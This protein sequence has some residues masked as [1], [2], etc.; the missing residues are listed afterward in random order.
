MKKQKHQRKI[1]KIKVQKSKKVSL[2]KKGVLKL[3]KKNNQT[4]SKKSLKKKKVKKRAVSRKI[5]NQ[6]PRIKIKIVGIGGGGNSIVS[7]VAQ[8]IKKV[9]FVVANTDFQ[10]LSSC[11]RGIKRLWFGQELTQ[12][13][14]AGM[15]PEVG[16][17][18]AEKEKEKLAKIFDGVDFSI[19]IGSLGGGTGSGA[20]PL[21]ASLARDAGNLTLGIFTM[22]FKFEGER[23]LKIAQDA[24]E[25]LK[26]NFNALIII[27][28][29]KVFEIIKRETGFKKSLSCVNECLAD[30]LGGLI[31]MIYSPGLI[32]IDFADVKTILQGKGKIAYLNTAT[33]KGPNKIEE[34]VKKVLK[35]PLYEYNISGAE[36]ILFNITSGKDLKMVEA[37]EISRIISGFNPRAKIIFGISQNSKYNNKIKITLFAVGCGNGIQEKIKK[38]IKKTSIKIKKEEKKPAESPSDSQAGKSAAAPPKLLEKPKSVEKPK[39]KPKIEEIQEIKTRRNALEIKK[40]EKAIEDAKLLQEKEW[41]IPTFLRKNK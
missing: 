34:A 9:D 37:E 17:A 15:N 39:P 16:K 10:A 24:L 3:G 5:F 32:N 4:K 8:K 38:I 21:F 6:I 12:G 27:S 26:Q 13:L 25:N 30:G 22:P 20:S 41:E 31:E 33:A 7:E 1:K 19:L 28:N 35:N 2:K 36:K 11:P 23:K 14:G 18:A 29:E 40:T